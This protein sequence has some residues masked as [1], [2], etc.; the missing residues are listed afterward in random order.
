MRAAAGNG[1]L[2]RMTHEG[3]PSPI[4]RHFTV[5]GFVSD[6]GQGGRTALHWHRL[7]LWLPPGGHIEPD[8]DPVQAMFREVTEETGLE[9]EIVPGGPAF[10]YASP[11]Q[12]APPAAMAVYDIPRDSKLDEPHQHI[13]FIYF[14]RP[15]RPDPVLPDDGMQWR[16]FDR[17]ALTREP[18]LNEDI[19]ELGLAAIDAAQAAAIASR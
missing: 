17:D 9:V 10:G 12:L 16:W 4:R 1:T 19:R 8:E 3:T 2:P 14:T 18:D 11:P 6:A 15:A 5:T 13:D 7:G